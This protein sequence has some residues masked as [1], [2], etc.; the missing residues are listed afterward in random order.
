[1]KTQRVF[2]EKFEL[3]QS[4]S[5]L[6][7]AILSR[8]QDLSQSTH[9]IK[10]LVKRAKTMSFARISKYSFDKRFERIFAFAESLSTSATLNE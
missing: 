8:Y 4:F 3:G 7:Y 2:T 6:T 9:F 1:M 10:L 5:N